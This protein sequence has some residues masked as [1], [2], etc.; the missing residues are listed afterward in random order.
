V[1][2]G[3]DRILKAMNRQHSV[4][5]YLRLIDR[6]RAARPDIAISGDYIVG[7]PGETDDDFR[8]M[9]AYLEGSPLTHV[10]VFPY[11]DRPGTE[12]SGLRPK[13]DGSVIRERARVIRVVGEQLARRFRQSQV[14]RRVR[15]LTVDDGQSVVTENY[16]K[17]RLNVTRTRNE[18]I[19][20]RV[21]DEIRG[22]VSM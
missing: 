6:V 18:W 11:S 12:A 21:E 3:S 7:F 1:Q 10:H 22:S 4:A 13:V 16:L 15:G 17:L 8:A 2:A 9:L 20:V 5:G 19:N 14:G